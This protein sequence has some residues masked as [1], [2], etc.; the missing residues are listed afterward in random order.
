MEAAK[1]DGAGHARI[2]AQIL[3]P[4]TKASLISLMVLSFISCWN[5]YMA[6]L[7]FLVKKPLVYA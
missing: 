3:L 5:E 6:P 4:L 7:I 1:I 2:F